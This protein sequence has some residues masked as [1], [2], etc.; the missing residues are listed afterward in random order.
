MGTRSNI[1]IVNEDDTVSS[2]YCHWDGYPSNNGKILLDHYTDKAKV[3]LL[4]SI[5]NLSSLGEH[6]GEVHC[7]DKCP[8]NTCNF[9][10]RDRHDSG[11]GA[12]TLETPSLESYLKE[13]TEEYCYVFINGKWKYR[14]NSN[15]LEDLT[16]EDC[17]D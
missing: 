13:D 6:I 14:A 5:G 11:V 3:E 4:I 16:Q 9:Y 8:E 10:G 1:A 15:E 12:L 7:F 17:E 2:I